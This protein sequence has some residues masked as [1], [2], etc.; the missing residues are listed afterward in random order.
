MNLNNLKPVAGSTH[1]EKRIGRG[2]GSGYG[3]TSTRGHKGAQSRSGYTRKL[4]FEGGQM[5]LQRRLPKYGFTNLKRVEYKPINLS[6][7]DALATKGNLTEVNVE[8]LIEA[9]FVSKNDRVKV[10]GNGTLSKTVTVAAH[11]FSKSA[12]A[13]IEAKAGTVVKL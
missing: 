13:A 3:G 8:T 1:H 9:G 6:V 10:L 2:Q 12:A 7:I 11:A 5:P 4:G